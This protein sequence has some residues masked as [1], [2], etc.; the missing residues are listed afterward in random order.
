MT[1]G[2]IFLAGADAVAAAIGA[3]LKGVAV[4]G[5]GGPGVGA[6]EAAT[7]AVLNDG[8]GLPLFVGR[9]VCVDG[10]EGGG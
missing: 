4:D 5:D 8:F 10:G 9:E 7:D 6:R 1:T 3:G 2:I